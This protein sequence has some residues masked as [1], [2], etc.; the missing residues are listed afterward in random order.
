M[1]ENNGFESFADRAK[2]ESSDRDL[3]E[4]KILTFGIN[5]LD[6]A[7]GGIVP[8]DLILIGAATGRGK[9]QL[10]VTIAMNNAL[11]GKNVYIFALES[12]KFEVERR[13]KYQLL[14]KRFYACYEKAKSLGQGYLFTR[15]YITYQ[16]WA[17]N[18]YKDDD[19]I[20]QCEEYAL[21]QAESLK[22]LHTYYRT[23]SFGL[24]EFTRVF[25][26]IGDKADL[27]IIDHIHYFDFGD[28][29]ENKAILEITKKIKDLSSLAKVPIIL[30]SHLRKMGKQEKTLIPPIEDFHGSSN[31]YKIATRVITIARGGYDPEVKAY[32]TYIQPLKNRFGS[33]R[34]EFVAKM[35]YDVN[36]ENYLP[37]FEVGRLTKNDKEFELLP[38]ELSPNWVK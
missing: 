29:N 6:K 28:D 24:E 38:E 31:L 27:V 1:N 37:Q 14:S 35:Y 25:S 4:G 11:L 3:N 34:C 15:K 23:N 7:L 13:I 5:Y 10:A 8:T 20:S 21:S 26:S 17:M 30:I 16:D 18:R 36:T 19:I 32:A 2:K 12:D 33:E 22:T 9:S